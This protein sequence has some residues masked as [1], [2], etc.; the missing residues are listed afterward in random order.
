MDD[1]NNSDTAKFIHLLESTDLQ[2][3]VIGPTHRHG[4]T[5]DL[6][7]SRRDE[8]LVLNTTILPDIISDHRVITCT[9]VCPRPRPTKLLVNYRKTK[10]I[11]IDCLKQDMNSVMVTAPDNNVSSLT[12]QYSMTLRTLYNEYA[13]EQTRWVTLRPNAPW[14][15]DDLCEAKCNKCCLERKYQTTA[16]EVH[17]EIFKQ[18]C[19]DYSKMLESAKTSHYKTTIENSDENQLF[20]VVD[21][22]FHRNKTTP[23]KTRLPSEAC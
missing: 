15:N 8:N 12:A 5:L 20:K 10:N 21:R 23:S 17:K 2:Q 1:L 19:R 13:P 3:H 22:M 18:A 16:L 7:L 9:L 6:V 14:Y 11:D 4:H